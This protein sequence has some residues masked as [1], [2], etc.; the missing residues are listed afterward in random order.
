[1][2]FICFKGSKFVTYP[3]WAP[4]WGIQNGLGFV[5]CPCQKPFCHPIIF[6]KQKPPKHP[7]RCLNGCFCSVN[8]NLGCYLGRNLGK[9]WAMVCDSSAAVVGVILSPCHALA[10]AT[11]THSF[12]SV[13]VYLFSLLSTAAG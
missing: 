9:H 7:I 11:K 5:N 4:N 8:N 3:P 1:M 2:T 10:G 13:V 12:C 6:P